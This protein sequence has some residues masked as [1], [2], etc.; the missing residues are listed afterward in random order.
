MDN[1]LRTIETDTPM[2]PH[3]DFYNKIHQ[4]LAV[5]GSE[6]V[7]TG[8]TSRPRGREADNYPRWY[9]YIP[10]ARTRRTAG[11]VGRFIPEDNDGASLMGYTQFSSLA[12]RCRCRPPPVVSYG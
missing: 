4:L 11:N 7:L 10:F 6:I 3:R 2:D 8:L 5:L 9:C 12:L 1:P